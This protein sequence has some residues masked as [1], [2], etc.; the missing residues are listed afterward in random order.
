MAQIIVTH[1]DGTTFNLQSKTNVSAITKASQTVELLGVDTV[2]LTVESATKLTF[3]IGDKITIIG[4]DYTLNT[5]ARERKAAGNHFIYDLQFEGVQ[6]DLLRASYNVNVDTTSHAIQDLNGDALTGDIKIFLDVLISNANRVFP[7]KWVLGTYPTGTDTKNLTFSDSDNCLSVLQNLCSEDNFNTEFSIAI[8]QSTGVRTLNIGAT[9]TTHTYTYQYGRGKGLYELTRQKV[10]STNI[11]TRLMVYGSNK[12]INTLKYRA[13]R[14]CLPTK[15]KSNSYL[16]NTASI[17]KFGVWEQT[18]IFEDVYPHRTGTITDFDPGAPLELFDSSMDFDLNAKDQAGNTL[19]LIPGTSAKIHFNTGKLAGYEFEI[20]EYNHTTKMFKIIKFT[21]ENGYTFPSEEGAAFQPAIGDKYVLIDI[22]MPDTYITAKETELQTKG[23]EWLTKYCQPK[24]AY[25]LSIDPFFLRDIVG[26][27]VESNIIWAGDYIPIKDTDLDVDKTIRVKSFTRDLLKD[28]SYNL[29]IADLAITVNTINRVLTELNGLDTI[30]KINNLNDPARARQSYKNSQEVLNMVFDGEGNYYSEKITPLSI[31]TTM[32]SVGAKY[33]QFGMMGTVFQTNYGGAKNRVVYTGGAL[34]HYAVLDSSNNPRT[35][36]VTDGDVVLGSDA[37]YYI[38]AKCSKTTTGASIFFSTTQILVD[39]DANYYHFLIGVINSV[40]TN[41]ERAIALMYGFTTI[42]GRFIKTGRIVSAAN[43]NRYFDIDTGEFRGS[44]TFTDGTNVEEAVNDAQGTADTA[45]IQI[46]NISS[47]N[48][49]SASEK[50]GERNRW[51]IIAA[52]KDGIDTQATTFGLTT[53]KTTYDNAFQALATYLNAGTTWTSGIPSWISDANLAT[54]TT[55]VGTTYRTT[56]ETYYAARTAVV[57]AIQNKIKDTGDL[58][59]VRTLQSWFSDFFSETQAQFDARWTNYAGSGEKTIV[60]VS[61]A[62]GGNVLRIGNGSGNDQAWLIGN[63]SIP[64]D[65]SRL[66]VIKARIR[67]TSGSG[68]CY[69]GIAGRNA[70]DT[71]WVNIS[72]TDSYTS[73]HYCAASSATPG[74]SWVEYT[75][76][77]KGNGTPTGVANNPLAPSPLHTNVRYIRPLVLCNY[78]AQAGI[79]EV[80]YVT[81]NFAEIDAETASTNYLKTALTG[82]T[83]IS[84]GLVGTNVLLLKTLAGVITGGF[85]GLGNDNIGMWTGGTYAQAIADI[86]N[87]IL[88]KDGTAKI[89][90]FEVLADMFQSVTDDSVFR[91]TPDGVFLNEISGSTETPRVELSKSAIPAVSLPSTTANAS[92]QSGSYSSSSTPATLVQIG[93]NLVGN[94]TVNGSSNSCTIKAFSLTL[95]WAGG[96]SYNIALYFRIILLKND[97]TYSTLHDKSWSVTAGSS[98]SASWSSDIVNKSNL[99]TGTYKIIAQ[100]SCTCDPP[101]LPIT[102]TFESA[103]VT[104]AVSITYISTEIKTIIGYNGILALSSS[105]QYMRYT[106]ANGLQVKGTTDIPGLLAS[107]SISNTGTHTNR[108]GAKNDPA[109]ATYT[110]TGI[111]DVPHAVGSAYY[112][113]QITPT[114]DNL[115]AMVVSKSANSFRVQVRNN[116][117]TATAG[118]FDYAI[119]GSN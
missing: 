68:T 102:L 69:V 87:I 75:G 65:P 26:S 25:S 90:I 33:M 114:A 115:H 39:S 98:L 38:Y 86:A 97:G 76:Y 111:Y 72:G 59:A 18:K 119:T 91:F 78:N 52:E 81:I 107:G 1:K 92:A 108:W 29:T 89:G 51:N 41:N 61:D 22:Y 6:Y 101:A 49:L 46:V 79:Y 60:A 37:A 15:N 70:T 118:S 5:P 82:S 23:Q 77:F 24:V 104:T 30:V 31:D 11:V 67:R 4:R 8:N 55:I 45:L 63:T 66:Y 50:S 62:T 47:D 80:D 19:Y 7:G 20:S 100:L 64:Y 48:V 58:L 34:T 84:G 13:Q 96:S 99:P 3:L 88:R 94:F 57:N 44:I 56:W 42:N 74:S 83:E 28:Y 2:D 117:G 54:N 85:S 103:A 14:L 110:A 106:D 105:S 16:E 35:W 21:D 73:Q 53:E 113:V 27:Q 10:S 109:N 17:A 9:G 32:L 71:A 12:N 93:S 40:G 116:S 43:N 36:T 95:S 112:S